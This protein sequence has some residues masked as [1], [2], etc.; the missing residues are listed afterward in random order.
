MIAT[1]PA[2]PLG[3]IHYEEREVDKLIMSKKKEVPG[4]ITMFEFQKELERIK[5]IHKRLKQAYK[6]LFPDKDDTYFTELLTYLD[7]N[8]DI[9]EEARKIDSE[10]KIIEDAEKLAEAIKRDPLLK[11]VVKHYDT[12]VLLAYRS[13]S[14]ASSFS[15]TEHGFVHDTPVLYH[16][17]I[18]QRDRSAKEIELGDNLTMLTDMLVIKFTALAHKGDS[19]EKLEQLRHIDLDVADYCL[20]RKLESEKKAK[21]TLRRDIVGLFDR[22]VLIA[23]GEP[24]TRARVMRVIDAYDAG[25]D[26]KPKCRKG[27]FR[28]SLS[29]EFA[30]EAVEKG[31]VHYYP[32]AL[33]AVD[34]KRHPHSYRLGTR[35][36]YLYNIDNKGVT[37]DKLLDW[38]SLMPTKEEVKKEGRHYTRLIRDTF[39]RD[40]LH[41][42]EIGVL[43]DYNYYYKGRL[44]SNL[45]EEELAKS[46]FDAWTGYVL[47]VKFA[48]GQNPRE[49]AKV[50]DEKAPTLPA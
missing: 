32:S 18:N 36:A 39:E 7:V 25:K 9:I 8:G 26:F 42:K 23:D 3:L 12:I 27:V 22:A 49:L 11:D 17:V 19:T 41:L 1:V 45:P 43:S 16:Q 34:T 21:E 24:G 2:I 28:I 4:Q 47:R 14:K 48:E 20:L 44:V 13:P 35:L 46:D 30:R 37:I 38:L 50:D 33:F 6:K 40:L 10:G 15:K 5:D 29:M 31:I